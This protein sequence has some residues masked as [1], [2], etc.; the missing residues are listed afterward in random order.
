M[1]WWRAAAA[2]IAIAALLSTASRPAGAEDDP[3]LCRDLIVT[4]SVNPRVAVIGDPFEFCATVTSVGAVTLEDVRLTI[5]GCPNTTVE[6]DQELVITI[7]R[8]A[9]GETHTHCIKLRCKE[10]GECR[11]TAHATDK[12]GIA[13]AGCICSAFCKGLPALQLEMIDTALDRTP[14]GIFRLGETFM[15]RLQVEND[16]GS[17]LT[18]DLMVRFSL[19]P[20][21]AFVRGRAERGVTIS[22]S[23]RAAT[24]SRFVLRPN[25]KL[26][27]EFEVKVVK[28]PARALVAARAVVVADG[29][30]VELAEETESTTLKR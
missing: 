1:A 2:T 3:C 15:Y 27:M 5:T 23:G 26:I 13:A 25:Q 6:P 18:P 9:Q 11:L 20:E 14:A 29:S 16:V 21:L 17:A 12:T 19:P 24:S 30:G 7:P 10:V 8:L 28:V 4:C 22:G